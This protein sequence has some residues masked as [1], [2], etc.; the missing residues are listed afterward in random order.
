MSPTSAAIERLAARH[1]VPPLEALEFYLVRLAIRD[2]DESAA[3]ADVELWA[4]LWVN[5]KGEPGPQLGLAV[6]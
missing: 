4:R 2:G 5:L 1:G 6:K 3:I